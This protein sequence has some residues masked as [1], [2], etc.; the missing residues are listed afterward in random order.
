MLSDGS[1]DVGQRRAGLGLVR[2][3]IGPLMENTGAETY[4]LW[5][6]KELQRCGTPEGMSSLSRHL[7]DPISICTSSSNGPFCK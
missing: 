1:E 6:R 3:Q 2:H 5:A 7:P 4:M